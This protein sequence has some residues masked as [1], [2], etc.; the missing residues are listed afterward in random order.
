MQLA[1][2]NFLEGI[3]KDK[4]KAAGVY[5]G[6]PATMEAARVRKLKA[7]GRRPFD[8]AKAP[9]IGRASVCRVLGQENGSGAEL[10]EQSFAGIRRRERIPQPPAIRRAKPARRRTAAGT[11]R[12]SALIA[13]RLQ[14]QFIGVPPSVDATELARKPG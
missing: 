1:N 6:R 8:I 3:A 9:K 5:K 14:R 10:T 7:G 4:A 11:K 2:T 12:A 13:I